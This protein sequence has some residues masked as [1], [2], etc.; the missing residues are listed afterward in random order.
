MVSVETGDN[1]CQCL[2]VA[3]EDIGTNTDR[4]YLLVSLKNNDTDSW[5]LMGS[6]RNGDT[7][8]WCPMISVRNSD[9]HSCL[10]NFASNNDSDTDT[11]DTSQLLME[12]DDSDS[13][14]L[15][16]VG[17]VRYAVTLYT[18]WTRDRIWSDIS[19]THTHTHACTRTLSL[20]LPLTHTK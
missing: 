9:T 4:K 19:H 15:V 13:K 6:V 2:M 14:H 3:I 12:T 20:S 8:S 1:D 10:V 5:C 16:S 7:D 17:M 18:P 11:P